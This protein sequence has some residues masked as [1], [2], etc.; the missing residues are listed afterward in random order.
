MLFL[1]E[2]VPSPC[3]QWP[4]LRNSAR[5]LCHCPPS[6]PCHRQGAHPMEMALQC[7]GCE[8]CSSGN[9]GVWPLSNSSG[10]VPPGSLCPLPPSSVVWGSQGA[11]CTQAPCPSPW[12]SMVSPSL[13]T[14]Q[15]PSELPSGVCGHQWVYCFPRLGPLPPLHAG[16][17]IAL[18]WPPQ[19]GIAAKAPAHSALLSLS[20]PLLYPG[21]G[22]GG[23]SA[24]PSI[25]PLHLPP[26]PRTPGPP[27]GRRLCW[28]SLA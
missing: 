20:K 26:P 12:P 21:P 25:S 10:P 9:L 3:Q 4:A 2:H 19:A 24:E 23:R 6:H 5:G 13:A 22:A 17:G 28:V 15:L 14:V 7:W 11:H 1:S 27:R 8:A 18:R 16:D